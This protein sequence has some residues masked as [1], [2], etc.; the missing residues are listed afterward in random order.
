MSFDSDPESPFG[1]ALRPVESS[2]SETGVRTFVLLPGLDA[3]LRAPA[4]GH[5]SPIALPGCQR[6]ADGWAQFGSVRARGFTLH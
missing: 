1:L 4:F 5:Q 3:L 2:G 6:P